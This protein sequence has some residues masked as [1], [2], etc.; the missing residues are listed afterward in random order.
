MKKT[1]R[2][3]QMNLKQYTTKSL[4]SEKC[5]F[6]L[7]TDINFLRMKYQLLSPMKNNENS[8][9][10]VHAIKGQLKQCILDNFLSIFSVYSS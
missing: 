8:I 3:D 2:E 5:F 4:I 1:L 9:D 6:F 10:Y 7:P